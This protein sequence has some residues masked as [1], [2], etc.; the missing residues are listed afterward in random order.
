MPLE[1]IGAG[2]TTQVRVVGELVHHHAAALREEFLRCCGES[3]YVEIDLSGVTQIDLAGVQWLLA[4]KQMHGCTVRIVNRSRAVEEM[5]ARSDMARL[6][7][8]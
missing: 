7:D 4:A 2:T 6:L 1:C 3:L 8:D 5:M